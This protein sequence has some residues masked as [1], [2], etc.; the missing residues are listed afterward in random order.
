[1]LNWVILQG[2]LSKDPEIRTTVNGHR[3]INFILSWGETKNEHTQKLYLLCRAWNKIADLISQ[4]FN[5]GEEL[6]VE[7]KMCTDAYK[8]DNE[9]KLRTY[10]YVTKVHF[11]QLR[12]QQNK[13]NEEDDVLFV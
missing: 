12:I 5:K 8:I 6:I 3:F 9:E 1:M 11:T 10:L 2:K 7:G 13:L 4:N